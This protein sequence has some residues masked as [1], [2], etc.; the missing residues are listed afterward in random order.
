MMPRM[1][2]SGLERRDDRV[3]VGAI[4]ALVHPGSI[5]ARSMGRRN[6]RCCLQ[7]R[8]KRVDESDSLA[9]ICR[10]VAC[11]AQRR[12]RDL[13]RGRCFPDADARDRRGREGLA[14]GAW[15]LLA[16]SCSASTRFRATGRSRAVCRSWIHDVPNAG[17]DAPVMARR[18]GVR[19]E[20]KSCLGRETS[21]SETIVLDKTAR[22][23]S[24]A[25][26]AGYRAGRAPANKGSCRRRHDPVYA[27]RAGMPTS[28]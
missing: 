15:R 16:S 20:P 5:P 12:P 1:H 6:G 22:R 26:M 10:A 18:A 9:P 25:V 24:P 2:S 27:D 4:T 21:M 3:R 28:A 8:S 13:R 14:A 17:E 19:V 7:E 11:G 23:R